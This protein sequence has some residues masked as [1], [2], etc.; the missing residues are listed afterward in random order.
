MRE[1]LLDARQV[2]L[3]ALHVVFE[4]ALPLSLQ[5][6]LGVPRVLLGAQH[7][8]LLPSSPTLLDA[9]PVWQPVLPSVVP[10]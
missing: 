2:L 3:G 1:V 7:V 9:V 10:V 8:V 4:T 6:P 5:V